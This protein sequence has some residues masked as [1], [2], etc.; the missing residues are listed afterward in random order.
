MTRGQALLLA[1]AA[2]SAAG[3]AAIVHGLL[4]RESGGVPGGTVPVLVAARAIAAGEKL[5]PS[6]AAWRNWPRDSVAEAMITAQSAPE[7]LGA[8]KYFVPTPM[9]AGE[10]VRRDRLVRRGDASLLAALIAP[11]MRAVSLPFRDE[12]G[13]AGLIGAN[14]RVDV[15]LAP[16]RRPGARAAPGE[17]ILR[18]VRVLPAGPPDGGG[19]GLMKGA[20]QKTAT[21]EVTPAQAELLA[22]ARRTG[23]IYLSLAGLGDHG[24]TDEAVRRRPAYVTV[25]K[26]GVPAKVTGD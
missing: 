8:Q 11:G 19:R 25:I 18:N 16:A 20:Q 15:I 7:F 5:E 9:L 12:N 22:G 26:F 6:A 13:V 17:T 4:T 21:L 10:P 1:A 23:E 3:S 14:D 2:V 24:R